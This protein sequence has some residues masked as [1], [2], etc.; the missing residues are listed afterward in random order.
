LYNFIYSTGE[1]IPIQPELLFMQISK[2]IAVI[3]MMAI[4]LLIAGCIT[5]EPPAENSVSVIYTKGTGP[6]PT[7][8]ATDQIDGYIAWQPFVE[9]APLAGIGKVLVY[10]GDLPPAGRWKNHP[11]CGFS[12]SQ[13][14]IDNNPDLTNALTASL[15]LSTRYIDEHPNESAEIVAD[16]LAG[17]GNFTYGNISVSSVEVLQKAFPTV[18][19]VNEPTDEWKDANLEFLYAQREL[20]VITGS[21][22]NTTDNESIDLLFDTRPYYAADAMIQAGTIIT[23]PV[24][25][26]PVPVGYLMSDHDAALFVAVKNWKYFEDTYGIAI[27]PRDLA[28][29]RPDVADLVVN[30]QRVAE[31]RLVPADAG[32]QLMQLMSTNTIQ[33]ALVG[34]SP[35]IAA[36]DKGT[37]VKII[38]ALNEEG[39]GIVVA[40]DAPANNWGSFITW[41][42][43][44]SASGQP[45]KIAAPGKGSI[46]DILLRYS[47][48][49]SGLSVKEG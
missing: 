26:K 31:I 14:V 25:E 3:A 22:T 2:M 12:A 16:W 37:P 29:S 1:F 21:L 17:K 41:A 9:V 46:Q 45:I 28:A 47:L 5:P 8:L 27:K 33:Y 32:P 6:M 20:G 15:I 39:S 10:S 24:Q 48:E 43:A 4:A 44:R 23:P 35:T 40:E 42:K 13:D 7:L 34:N 49:E 38:M 18:K 11:C 19:F 30:G 36:V